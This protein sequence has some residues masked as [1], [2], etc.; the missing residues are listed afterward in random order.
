M[1]S[2]SST[3]PEEMLCVKYTN[4][5]W[6]KRNMKK[7]FIGFSFLVVIA[8]LVAGPFSGGY[9]RAD[10]GP[11][12]TVMSKVSGLLS[13]DVA[14]ATKVTPCDSYG[15]GVIGAECQFECN[16]SY[17]LVERDAC[18]AGCKKAIEVLKTYCN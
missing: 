7:L 17:T 12:K 10:F 18:Y 5:E 3:H 2:T 11:L 14:N 13:P 9:E 15:Q 8:V 16:K 1:G 6:R 4:I